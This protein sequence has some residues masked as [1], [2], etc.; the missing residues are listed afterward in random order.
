FDDATRRDIAVRDEA[1]GSC[2]THDGREVSE[3]GGRGGRDREVR[4]GRD[5]R[6]GQG[7]VTGLRAGRGRPRRRGPWR[8]RIRR[9]AGTARGSSPGAE[10]TLTGGRSS[11]RRAGRGGPADSVCGCG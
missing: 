5:R 7:M 11:R 3:G 1:G 10:P 9:S 6:G 4:W 2:G 8:W